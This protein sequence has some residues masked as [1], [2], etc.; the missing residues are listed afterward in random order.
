MKVTSPT[1][2][3]HANAKIEVRTFNLQRGEVMDKISASRG[4]RVVAAGIGWPV[5]RVET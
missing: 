4:A 2:D 3:R 1:Q 5:M